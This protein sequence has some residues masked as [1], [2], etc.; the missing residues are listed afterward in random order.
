[1]HG[2]PYSYEII[3]P[4]TIYEYSGG[5]RKSLVSMTN[6][7]QSFFLKAVHPSFEW[8]TKIRLSLGGLFCE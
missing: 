1:M 4:L 7:A 8:C 2:Q 3:K 5:I 6:P